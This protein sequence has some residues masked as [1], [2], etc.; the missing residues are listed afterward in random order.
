MTG[1]DAHVRCSVAQDAA[2]QDEVGESVWL[3]TSNVW[4]PEE[5]DVEFLGSS[6]GTFRL[7]LN[8]RQIFERRDT[9]AYQPDSDRV[10]AT[11][12]SGM[13]RLMVWV[14]GVDNDIRFQVRFRPKS[15]RAEHERLT[16][17]VLEGHGNV[18]RGHELMLNKEKS[19][20]LKCHRLDQQGNRIGPDLS[21][22][23]SRFSRIHLIESILEP[24]RTLAPSY[25]TTVV[26]LND[27]RVLTG[28]KLSETA[29]SITLGDAEGNTHVVLKGDIEI[30]QVQDRSTMPDGLEKRF[31]D[32]ELIDLISFLLSG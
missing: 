26:A 23:G 17:L 21:D 4:V 12:S 28:V 15:S 10:D 1:R 29:Q 7:W 22:I 9:G 8:G 30:T 31:T 24:N 11:L 18:Q 27:G 20:C 16:R 14:T 25:A 13:N 2:A 3:A 32:T 19:L 5:M 6:S